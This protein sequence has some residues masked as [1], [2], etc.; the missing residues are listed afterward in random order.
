[1]PIEFSPGRRSFL[2]AAAVTMPMIIPASALG[3]DGATA[4]SERITVGCIGVGGRGSSN[5]RAFLEAQGAQV[6]AVCDVD[7]AHRERARKQSEL[8]EA[9]SYLDF[10]EVLS[11]D[12][13]DTVS[14]G[15]PDHWHSIQTIEAAK[16][17]KDIF[18]EKPV[19]LTIT[20]G[21]QMADAV[22]DHDRILQV[23]TW[24]RSL[25]PCRRA[26]E[27]VR[28]GYIGELHMIECGVPEGYQIRGEFQPGHPTVPVPDGLD[29]D[30]WLGPAPEQPYTPGRCHFNFRWLLDYSAGYITDWGAHYYDIAQWGNGTDDTG[31]VRIAGTAEF[32]RKGLYDASVK[33]LIEYEYANGVRL[34]ALT[35]TDGSKHGIRFIGSEGWIHVESNTI[36]SA[37]ETLATLELKNS[38][39]RLYQSDN[40][41]YNFIEC[42][43][44]RKVP[45]APIEVGHRS[46]SICHLGHIATTLKRELKWDPV[47]EQFDGDAEANAMRDRAK[48]APWTLS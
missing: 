16:A 17:G 10:R 22:R 36:T 15:T 24:R 34:I 14:I 33:H 48:R 18:C 19:S 21:R 1:M 31:P 8:T 27:L 37:P 29:Y 42:V 41:L 4:P 35:S 23:G 38:D 45:A 13:I 7:R 44:D 47:K 2:K 46:A 12:D 30:R 39:T 40:H 25:E 43:K 26:C 3:R 32:P 5:M 9:D 11:R 28:N 20:E 6:V